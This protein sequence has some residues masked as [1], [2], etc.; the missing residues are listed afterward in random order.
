MAA[1]PSNRLGN[2]SVSAEHGPG[3]KQ[4]DIGVSKFFPITESKSLEFRAEA[5]NAFNFPIFLVNAYSIDIFG[6]AQEGVV[7]SSL[8]ARN[9]QFASKFHF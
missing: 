4:V 5:V 9:I 6:G 2:C 3:L 8:G 7:N 1:P